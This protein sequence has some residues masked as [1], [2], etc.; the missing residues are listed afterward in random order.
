MRGDTLASGGRSAT[1][2]PPKVSQAE[3]DERVGKMPKKR[4]V[5]HQDDGK[6]RTNTIYGDIDVGLDLEGEMPA[7]QVK[8][9]GNRKNYRRKK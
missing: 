6:P 2:G 7:P 1:F 3:W 4:R 8:P 5:I 9:M